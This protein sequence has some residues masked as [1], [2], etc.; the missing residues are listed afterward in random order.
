MNILTRVINVAPTIQNIATV[1]QKAWFGDVLKVFQE[2]IVSSPKQRLQTGLHANLYQM[3]PSLPD[4][5]GVN[6]GI[7]NGGMPPR[8]DIIVGVHDSQAQE[9]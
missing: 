3:T 4:L 1:L 6:H 2:L 9:K 7:F 5:Q 8:L